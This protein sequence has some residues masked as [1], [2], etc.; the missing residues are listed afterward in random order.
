MTERTSASHVSM[1]VSPRSSPADSLATPLRSQS[2]VDEITDR[3]VTALAIGEYL[4]GSRL[5]AERDL[6]SALG[7]G[8]MTVRA[9]LS[10]LLE[11]G[12]I[13]TQR[14]KSGG[15]FVRE[16]WSD[17]SSAP[18]LR[19]LTARWESLVDT[20]E[21]VRRL[22]GTIAR[23][24]AENRDVHD[25]ERLNHLVDE[26]AAAD[27]GRDSQR[28]DTLLHLAIST[29][30]R[31]QTLSS[32]LLELESRVSIVAPAH[33]WGAV[34]GMR[35]MESRALADHRQ[36]VDAIIEHDGDLASDIAREHVR[37]DLELLQEAMRRAQERLD[38]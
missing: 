21:A 34:D 23:A 24:A 28:V 27:S 18:V 6:A 37:I 9:A 31:N 12:L 32:V 7:V 13:E 3:L 30:A 10:R 29:A 22:H 11:R 25:V 38:S 5:P 35:R 1:S 20:S 17:A 26:F 19:T 2:R 14:G 36:L 16:Q 8:R 15:S 4:P 33:L